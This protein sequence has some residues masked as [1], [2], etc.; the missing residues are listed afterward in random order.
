MA[1]VKEERGRHVRRRRVPRPARVQL[2]RRRGKRDAAQ[3]LR[4]ISRKHKDRLLEKLSRQ[5]SELQNHLHHRNE[6]ASSGGR[7]RDSPVLSIDLSRELFSEGEGEAEAL[8]PAPPNFN[9]TLSTNVKEPVV[10]KSAPEHLEALKKIQRFDDTEWSGIRY[11]ETQKLFSCSPG[12]VELECNDE[13]KALD[14]SRQLQLSERSYAALTLALLKQKEALQVGIRDFLSWARDSD[15]LNYDSIM[16]K[17]NE[18]LLGGDFHKISTDTLQLVCGR[19][20]DAVE[21]RRDSILASTKDPLIKSA[22]RKIPPTCSFLFEPVSFCT[23]IEKAGGV[24]K[25]FWLQ[26][27]AYSNK[28]GAQPAPSGTP[29]YPAQGTTTYT[30]AQGGNKVRNQAPAQGK[31]CCQSCYRD[32]HHG[33]HTYYKE[34]DARQSYQSRSRDSF[35][36][37]GTGQ[38]KRGHRFPS[39]GGSGKRH[40]SPSNRDKPTNKRKY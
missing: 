7:G 18:N 1:A 29:R 8:T 23:A 35:R 16:E 15:N 22:L 25:A 37:R 6:T 17:I 33:E 5:V 26:P 31:T 39:R 12:F 40:G 34:R 32:N 4:G 3:K 11:A 10:P 21:Q 24:K 30:P 14:T 20:A 27:K 28:A 13:V 19:R 9:L 36:G 38:T 2:P